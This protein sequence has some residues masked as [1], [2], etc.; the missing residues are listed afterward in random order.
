LGTDP[1][2]RAP[3][4][5]PSARGDPVTARADCR[6]GSAAVPKLPQLRSSPLVRF[7]VCATDR[8][9]WRAR[10]TWRQARAP[11]PSPS[12]VGAYGG[13]RGPAGGLCL[14]AAGVSRNAAVPYAPGHRAARD[15]DGRDAYGLARNALSPVW[16]YP[17]SRA[18]SRVPLWVWASVD[19]A[20]RRA[21]RPATEQSQ[22]RTGILRVCL[23]SAHQSGRRSTR[24]RSGVGSHLP[25]F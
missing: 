15:P 7:P 18:S 13:H 11:R 22:R 17:Q 19:R 14:W 6:A 4:G 12:V 9:L 3:G 25:P 21:V 5:H 24:R 1:A 2:R 8:P 23:G 10:E 20:H 16:P